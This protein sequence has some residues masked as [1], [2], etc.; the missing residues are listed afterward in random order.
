MPCRRSWVRIPSAAST[1][2]PWDAP[3]PRRPPRPMRSAAR[4]RASGNRR[5]ALG[6]FSAR[7]SRDR[8]ARPSEVV[9]CGAIGAGGGTETGPGATRAPSAT[10][11]VGDRR[12]RRIGRAEAEDRDTRPTGATAT[13]AVAGASA[14]TAVAASAAVAA[15]GAPVAGRFA[16]GAAATRRVLRPGPGVRGGQSNWPPRRL[17]L[18]P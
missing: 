15:S 10:A 1:R 9:G 18:G 2:F 8:L 14:C 6:A 16:E 13:A 12:T 4:A 17:Y 3:A 11:A 7:W 5:G